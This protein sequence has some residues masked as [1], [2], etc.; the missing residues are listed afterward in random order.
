MTGLY[1]RM[2]GEVETIGLGDSL[3]DLPMLAAVD[4][5]V[6]VQ[7]KDHTWEN[8]DLPELRRIPGVGPQGWSRAIKEILGG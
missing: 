2:W 8:I 3:N 7:K 5:P 4:I 6:L 1:R